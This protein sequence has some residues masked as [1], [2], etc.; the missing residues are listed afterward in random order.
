MTAQ[1][2]PSGPVTQGQRPGSTGERAPAGSR[3]RFALR[4]ASTRRDGQR[5][6]KMPTRT[7]RVQGRGQQSVG[8]SLGREEGSAPPP[9]AVPTRGLRR[10]AGR[11]QRSA[12]F[13][14]SAHTR[15]GRA[16]A[17]R[18]GRGPPLPGPAGPAPG[19][20]GAR[21]TAGDPAAQATRTP[22]PGA[23]R[24]GGRIPEVPAAPE[25]H[26]SEGTCK[27]TPWRSRPALTGRPPARSRELPTP[28]GRLVGFR[29]PAGTA[30]PAQ[31]R[32]ARHSPVLPP[33]CPPTP[34][35]NR[36]LRR[37]PPFPTTRRPHGPGH[38]GH[39]LSA[40]TRPRDPAA[41]RPTLPE[42]PEAP[43]S[44]RAQAAGSPA[45]TSAPRRKSRPQPRSPP[46]RPEVPPPP[47]APAGS[48]VSLRLGPSARAARDWGVRRR[49]WAPETARPR[50]TGPTLARNM[51]LKQEF[52]HG[53]GPV[54]PAT[55]AFPAHR[56]EVRATVSQKLFCAFAEHLPQCP[57]ASL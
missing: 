40:L 12:T 34:Q 27:V 56:S 36:A 1:W 16:A 53:L 21:T 31:H 23:E 20:H 39:R 33:S 52:R 50:P 43:T 54:G 15:R 26:G 42:P 4:A 7:P 13:S 47:C 38:A 19:G 41:L 45:T 6:G 51:C 55:A 22:S 29:G 10:G 37:S 48:P 46:R 25:A 44:L 17:V 2:N 30:A 35:A 3:R 18:C 9:P 32:T 49:S 57:C 24:A 11:S 28:P 5:S 8:P 14:G